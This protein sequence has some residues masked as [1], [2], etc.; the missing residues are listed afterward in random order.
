MKKPSDPRHSVD[1]R[2]S[3]LAVTVGFDPMDDQPYLMTMQWMGI[4]VFPDQ[5]VADGQQERVA[6]ILGCL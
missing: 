5:G 6:R 3:F 2:A 1:R 4:P